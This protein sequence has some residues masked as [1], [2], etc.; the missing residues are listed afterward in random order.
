MGRDDHKK[1]E[2]SKHGA[3]RRHL[4]TI[5]GSKKNAW[6]KL[7]VGLKSDV[8][9]TSAPPEDHAR[10]FCFKVASDV[11]LSLLLRG[12]RRAP[13]FNGVKVVFCVVCGFF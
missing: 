2:H 6:V 9:D 11:K 10:Y 7:R 4:S 13:N 5:V 8:I 12:L 1:G 3:H